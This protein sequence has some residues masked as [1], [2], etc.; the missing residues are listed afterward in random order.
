M[1]DHD[2]D[3]MDFFLKPLNRHLNRQVIP[4]QQLLH[5]RLCRLFVPQN[6]GNLLF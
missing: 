5:N 3:T 2:G 1:L 4:E 6:K